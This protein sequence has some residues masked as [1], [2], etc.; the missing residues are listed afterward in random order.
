MNFSCRFGA[1]LHKDPSGPTESPPGVLGDGDPHLFR[2]FRKSPVRGRKRRRRVSTN[3]VPASLFGRGYRGKPFCRHR[4]LP[5]PGR[6]FRPW[7][8]EASCADRQ[9]E[10]IPE[11][12]YTKW[13]DYDKIKDKLTVRYRRRD[14]YRDPSG[15]TEKTFRLPDGHKMPKISGTGRRSAAARGS[16][17]KC[18]S[19]ACA[20]VN[21]AV[22][23]KKTR[24]PQ[25][26]SSRKKNI[27]P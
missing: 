23:R 12:K 18:G 13:F 10:T 5:V 4:G 1:K 25:I 20:A 24:C 2:P 14:F 16:E 3:L 15:R 7:R 19:R 22:W 21:H 17:V 8:I 9:N 6:F 26:H 27:R 11:N